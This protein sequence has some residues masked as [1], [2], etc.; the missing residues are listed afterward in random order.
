ME[1]DLAILVC[2]P[3][4]DCRTHWKLGSRN[5]TGYRNL[6]EEISEK[7]AGDIEVVALRYQNVE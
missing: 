4:R 7:A 3:I 2:N 5:D 1:K 6:T